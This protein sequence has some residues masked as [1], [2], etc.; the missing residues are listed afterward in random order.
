MIELNEHARYPSRFS[1]GDVVGFA[2]EANY[3]KHPAEIRG[4][5][6]TASKVTYDLAMEYVSA[7]KKFY[8]AT[9]MRNVDSVYV[10]PLEDKDSI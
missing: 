7:D 6:F 10:H 5:G 9:V 2:V 1:I 8:N 3:P 4:V